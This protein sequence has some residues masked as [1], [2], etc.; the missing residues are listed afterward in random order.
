[1]IFEILNWN[2]SPRWSE[3]TPKIRIMRTK[4]RRKQID[5][6]QCQICGD[7]KGK[8]YDTLVIVEIQ[9]HHII[10]KSEGGKD[11][12][13][14]LITLCDLCH[15]VVNPQRW[16]EYFGYKG[17]TQ[18]MEWIRKE[19]DEYLKSDIEERERRKRFLWNQ[20]AIE[21]KL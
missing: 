4:N 21:T 20:F 16:K 3:P 6:Y 2:G 5:N 8:R 19:F 11:E 10:P 7:L 12:F 15:A 1:M 13:E 18:N 14:N 17:T 9:A